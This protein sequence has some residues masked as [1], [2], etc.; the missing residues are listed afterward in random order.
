M[1]GL[2]LLGFL[3]VSGDEKSLFRSDYKEVGVT[4]GELQ[5]DIVMDIVS[6]QLKF[7]LLA[8]IK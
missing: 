3:R 1:D 6:F 7:L 5:A 8:E 2:A 4:P